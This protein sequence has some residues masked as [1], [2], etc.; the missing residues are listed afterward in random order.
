MDFFFQGKALI[1]RISKSMSAG[2][3]SKTW[4]VEFPVRWMHT[5][6]DHNIPP[7]KLQDKV[8]LI[9]GFF[10]LW[11]RSASPSLQN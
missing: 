5:G 2:S 4:G 11:F 7:R 3:R 1:C 6:M 8:E 10:W 9:I